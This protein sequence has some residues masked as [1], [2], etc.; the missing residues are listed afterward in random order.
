MK[1]NFNSHLT[2]GSKLLISGVVAL[3]VL[4]YGYQQSLDNES[5]DST[6]NISQNSTAVN[7]H[8]TY[9]YGVANGGKP[10]AMKVHSD[11]P[12]KAQNQ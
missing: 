5:F 7:W 6:T 4:L 9:H 1:S 2:T 10:V 11:Y 12:A 8:Q 3:V